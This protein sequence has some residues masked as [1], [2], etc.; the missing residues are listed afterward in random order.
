MADSELGSQLSSP[1]VAPIEA[2]C[3][4]APLELNSA[5]SPFKVNF[6][7]GPKY[8]TRARA[9]TKTMITLN[10]G[11]KLAR[12]AP[13]LAS[14]PIT[15]APFC[16]V[17]RKRNKGNKLF[18]PCTFF[19]LRHTH[20]CSQAGG[21]AFSGQR[22]ATAK[23]SRPTTKPRQK[24]DWRRLISWLFGH[25]SPVSETQWRC[26]PRNRMPSELDARVEAQLEASESASSTKRHF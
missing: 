11:P 4:W 20:Y 12:S 23:R 16:Q 1:S 17:E 14:G 24:S 15:V 9:E 25:I 22:S 26:W 19:G 5:S 21:R 13:E 8:E 10:V 18:E 3:C 2:A 7:R 6:G